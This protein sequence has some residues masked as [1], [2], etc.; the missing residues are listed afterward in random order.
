MASFVHLT[1]TDG[2]PIWVNLDHVI[3]MTRVG[4]DYTELVV[5]TV[6]HQEVVGVLS[7]TKPM[8][9]F[10]RETAEEI[11]TNAKPPVSPSPR[12]SKREREGHET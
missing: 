4:H 9:M 3:C 7:V 5:A 10:V 11:E 12:R 6:G 8:T 2:K 1:Q